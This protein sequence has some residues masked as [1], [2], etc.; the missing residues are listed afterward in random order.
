MGGDRNVELLYFS[1]LPPFAMHS[2][3]PLLPFRQMWCSPLNYLDCSWYIELIQAPL[4]VIIH[5]FHTFNVLQTQH[6]VGLLIFHAEIATSSTHTHMHTHRSLSCLSPTIHTTHPHPLLPCCS[7]TL[8]SLFLAPVCFFPLLC[9]LI[10]L[11]EHTLPPRFLQHQVYFSRKMP[12]CRR[13][14]S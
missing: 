11:K 7:S 12:G 13:F 9:K 2:F 1:P 4:L 3:C 6:E 5:A 14:S 10:W 8:L